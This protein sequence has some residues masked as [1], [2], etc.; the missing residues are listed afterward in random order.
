MKS[1]QKTLTM[2]LTIQAATGNTARLRSAVWLPAETAHGR[3]REA[4]GAHALK[5]KGGITMTYFEKATG[6]D[7]DQELKPCPDTEHEWVFETGFGPDS[8]W[9]TITC[10]KCG[11]TH[12][13]VFY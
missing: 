6:A 10:T 11:M 5:S 7:V 1:S 9:E 13:I 2:K 4:A 8:G 3:S 12:T